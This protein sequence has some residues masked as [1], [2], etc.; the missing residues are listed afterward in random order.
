MEERLTKKE[1]AL[2]VLFDEYG[3]DV[4]TIQGNMIDIIDEGIRSVICYTKPGDLEVMHPAL[5]ALQRIKDVVKYAG[6]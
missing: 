1:E 6:Y 5:D 2:K 4:R 3:N